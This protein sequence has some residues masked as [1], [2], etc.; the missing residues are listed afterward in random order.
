MAP[1]PIHTPSPI[2][3]GRAYSSP[4][5]R[6]VG[7]IQIAA[8]HLLFFAAVTHGQS[9]HA[10]FTARY[11]HCERSEA[12]SRRACAVRRGLLRRCA[13]AMTCGVISMARKELAVD[14]VA[15]A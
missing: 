11:C 7:V 1:P 4:A 15:E 9:R 5:V 8:Q 13:L 2:R 12:I 14:S 3:I 10:V 6:V